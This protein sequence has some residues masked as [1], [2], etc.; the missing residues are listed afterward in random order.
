MFLLARDLAKAQELQARDWPKPVRVV[1]GDLGDVDAWSSELRGVDAV[2]TAVSCGV[3]TRE[4]PL[5]A[6]GLASPPASW[7]NVPE[8]ID[9]AGVSDLCSAAVE[10][11]VPR[12]VAVTTASTATPWS[13]A[14]VFLNLACVG[15]VKWKFE[16]EQAIRRSG[17]EFA[18]IR[19]FGLTDEEGPAHAAYE[20]GKGIE[21]SQGRTEGTRKRIPR[22]DVAQLC[23]EALLRPRGE[24]AT[25]E[26]W[27][28]DRHQQRLPWHELRQ[29]QAGQE[30]Q[31]VNHDPAIQAGC[32]VVLGAC[33]LTL[34][35]MSTLT[36]RM[37]R[38]VR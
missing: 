11:G 14:A 36:R 6:L 34:A 27:A 26:C 23:H 28:T 12:I 13:L 37:L 24:R 9:S 2:A 7:R 15:S 3:R 21:W 1:Q 25:F 20:T 17:L 8:R 22:E 5:A 18:I 32:A 19:P 38:L 29:E 4:S 30:V 10:N 31:G 35:G 16:G 33:G